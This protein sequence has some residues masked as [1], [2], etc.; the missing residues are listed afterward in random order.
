MAQ[1]TS[2][3]VMQ[4]RVE[5]HD[6]LDDFPTP[7][8]ATRALLEHVIIPAV[9]PVE[10]QVCWEPAANR[11]YMVRPLTEYFGRVVASDAHDYGVGYEVRDFLFPGDDLR[12]DWVITNPPF[13][14][15]REFVE[16]ALEV[17]KAGVAMFVRL[18]FLESEDRYENLFRKHPP[19]IVAQFVERVVL[20]KGKIVDPNIPIQDPI[21]G[22]LR[23][24][25]TATAYTWI[26]WLHGFTKTHFQWIPPCRKKLERP[27]DYVEG[28]SA[29]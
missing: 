13:R 9:G 21:T 20:H 2:T 23:K 3:A 27:G 25:S 24:P 18:A 5:P 19:A 29:S 6:S 17:S 16:K 12:V 14:L 28:V 11:G 8:W 4:R 26:V 1:N 7:P 15:G 10:R 22:K